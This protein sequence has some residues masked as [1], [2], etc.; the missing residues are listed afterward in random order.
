MRNDGSSKSVTASSPRTGSPP[1]HRPTRGMGSGRCSTHSRA[2]RAISW[3]V[4]GRQTVRSRVSSSESRPST[5]ARRTRPGLW[6]PDPGPSHHWSPAGSVHPHDLHR[7][8]RLI[9]RRRDLRIEASRP[10]SG[11][12]RLRRCVDRDHARPP[13]GAACLWRRAPRGHPGGRRA[14]HGRSRRCGRRR[15]LGSART[16]SSRSPP[17]RRRWA[18]SGGKQTSRP[19]SNRW[20]RRS[21]ATSASP[22][23]SSPRT[24]AP[25]PR[26]NVLG[27]Q[28]RHT[29]DQ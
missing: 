11:G 10:C 29:R 28:W 21:S 1:P 5:T 7:G 2:H 19:W 13:S 27:H 16:G 12:P 25:L 17:A 6:R 3:M 15:H 22:L 8:V 24:T 9:S 23:P 4:E 20:R 26:P 18:A 14:R